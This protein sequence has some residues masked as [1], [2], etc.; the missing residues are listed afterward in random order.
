MDPTP[1][2]PF[3][4]SKTLWLGVGTVLV[5]ALALFAGSDLVK[6]YPQIASGLVLAGGL[7][8]IILRAITT[9]PISLTKE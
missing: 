3:W 4:Q 5:A 2:I 8:Q 6:G 7:L 1:A 9:G